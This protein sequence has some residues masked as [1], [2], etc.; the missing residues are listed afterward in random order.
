MP[1]A[2]CRGINSPNLVP[3][4]CFA[5][6]TKVVLRSSFL[7]NIPKPGCSHFIS[8][9]EELLRVAWGRQWL[10]E[11]NKQQQRWRNCLTENLSEIHHLNY[12]CSVGVTGFI[13]PLLHPCFSIFSSL[14]YFKVLEF[15]K[16]VFPLRFS[17]SQNWLQD[18]STKLQL[19]FLR[20]AALRIRSS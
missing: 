10:T 11:C 19:K 13:Q 14:C 12:V 15:P 3:A 2:G 7:H 9:S 18:L 1:A 6:D 16:G 4:V 8:N 17:Y 5:S 20:Q